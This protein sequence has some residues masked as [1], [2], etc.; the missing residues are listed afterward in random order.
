MGPGV[1]PPA[2]IR[3]V[4][5]RYSPQGQAARIQGT[6]LVE[7]LIDELGRVA[8]V[9]VV[10][11]LGFGLD[12]KAQAAVEKW[13]FHPAEKNGKPV[14]MLAT[15]EVNFRYPGIVFDARTEA[16]RSE[17]N[18]ALRSIE[19]SNAPD[20][21]DAL[22]RLETLSGQ[23]YPPA[24]YLKGMLMAEGK[25]LPGDPAGALR[26]LMN[27]A[28]KSYGPAVY[29]IG[30]RY[31][32][33]NQLP[34]DSEKGLHMVRDAAMLGSTLAQYM[35]G[36]R[37]ETGEGV[38]RDPAQARRYYRLCASRKDMACQFKIGELLLDQPGRKE[39]DLIQ[40]IAWLEL[41]ARQGSTQALARLAGERPNLTLEQSAW[42][43]KLMAEIAPPQ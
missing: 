7:V 29:E 19:R 14:R 43:R 11:P 12:E 30:K 41:S 27:A 22:R 38:P 4:E 15:I 26:W 3:M 10:S 37:Y 13:L 24:M 36:T 21:P 6:V 31:L 40:A 32:E 17:Y 25:L 33:G 35:L 18:S 39:R 34:Q 1:K 8:D 20:L 9:A 28:K 16:R 2:V 42:V 5:P 23:G